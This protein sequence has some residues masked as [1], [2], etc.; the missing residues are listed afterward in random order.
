VEILHN[1]TVEVYDVLC[2]SGE[3]LSNIL[4]HGVS[5]LDIESHSLSHIKTTIIKLNNR[6]TNELQY[7]SHYIADPGIL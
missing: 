4:H 6:K 5:Y 7:S 2:N 3:E 1:F